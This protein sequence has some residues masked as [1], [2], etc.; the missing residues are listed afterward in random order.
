MRTLTAIFFLALFLLLRPSA[1]GSGGFWYSDDDQDYFAHASSIAYGQ[2]PHYEKEFFN[3]KGLPLAAVGP[4]ILAAPFVFVF[5]LI[6]RITQAPVI[7]ART[8]ETIL[9][10][11]SLY[12]FMVATIFYFWLGCAL[13]HQ[14]LRR[15][16]SSALYA[17]QVVPRR[18]SRRRRHEPAL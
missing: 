1:L 13:L 9:H 3:N 2:F 18:R 16:F 12:G 6:D 11:W 5:S 14:G 8:R 17:L 15:H 7:Q 10:S 4:G